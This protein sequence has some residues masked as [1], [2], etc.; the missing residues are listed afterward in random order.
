MF[1]SWMRGLV[2]R[3]ARPT[4][5]GSARPARRRTY[6]PLLEQLEHRL[7]PAQCFWTGAGATGSWKL[8]ANWNI[9][10]PAMGQVIPLA[11]DDIIFPANVASHSS[12]FDIGSV[13]GFFV[14]SIQFQDGGYVLGGAIP[15]GVA[16]AGI[17]CS[18]G[19]TTI[20]APL[21]LVGFVAGGGGGNVANPTSILVANGTQLF[22]DG[23]IQS[24]LYNVP[25]NAPPPS[26]AAG[27]I[28][29]G[30]N[31][32]QIVV[33]ANNTYVG[34]T[35]IAGGF[36]TIETGG[37]LGA[38]NANGVTVSSGAALQ[39]E[40][41][42]G[43]NVSIAGKP[44]TINGTGPTGGGALE[45]F[46]GTWTYSG[47]LQLSGNAAIGADPQ[48]PGSPVPQITINGL[49]TDSNNAPVNPA[50]Q[51]FSMTIAGGE[52]GV[53]SHTGGNVVFTGNQNNVFTG[54]VNVNDGTL[55]LA[56]TPGFVA[57]GQPLVTNPVTPQAVQFLTIGDASGAANTAAVVFSGASNQLPGTAAAAFIGTQVTI[58]SD[59][60]LNMG[61]FSQQIYG[62]NINGGNVL[63][64]NGTLTLTQ[65]TT[66]ANGSGD[67]LS[68]GGGSITT[69]S[70]GL[71]TGTLQIQGSVAKNPR[72]FTV[73][74]GNL[75]IS[76]VVSSSNSQQPV[77]KA[78]P[79]TLTLT[80]SN[81]IT[82]TFT[83]NPGGGTVNL[84]NSTALGTASAVTVNSGTAIQLQGTVTN[85]LNISRPLTINGA[86][87]TS[88][89]ALEN[90]SG[91][92]QWTSTIALAGP[93]FFGLDAGQLTVTGVISGANSLTTNGPGTLMLNAANTYTGATTINGGVLG[94]TGTLY[95]GVTP[96][97]PVTIANGGTLFP[98]AAV[99][100]T[101]AL[102]TNN[103]VLTSPGTGYSLGQFLTITGAGGNPGTG[104][105]AIV[106]G[107]NASGGITALAINSTGG[108]YLPGSVTITSSSGSGATAIVAGVPALFTINDT[109]SFSFGSFFQIN[110]L[111]GA[112]AGG[113]AGFDQLR[114]NAANFAVNLGVGN[115]TFIIPAVRYQAA[116]NQTYAI[117]NTAVAS[118]TVTGTFANFTANPSLFTIP[119][120]FTPLPTT[121]NMRLTYPAA[122]GTSLLLAY[123]G[124]PPVLTALS[125][126]P[127]PVNLGTSTTLNGTFL[128]PDNTPRTIVISWGDGSPNTT[129]NLAASAA[130]TFTFGASSVPPATHTYATTGAFPVNVTITDTTTNLSTFGS[131]TISVFNVRYVAVSSDNT[132]EVRVFNVPANA[133]A[134]DFFA[135]NPFAFPGGVRVAVGDVNGDSIPD[136]ITVPGPGGPPEVK[137][138]DGATGAVIRDFYAYAGSMTAGMFV[139]S[140][141]GN[142]IV[143]GP[144]AGFAPEVKVF[145]A[146]TTTTLF[147]FFAYPGF[148][149]GGVRVA[150]GDVN[151]DATADILTVTGP[152]QAPEVRAFNGLNTAQ[153]Y[154]FF[155]FGGANIP[156][157]AYIASADINGDG[158]ADFIVGA[159]S[160]S[161]P[162]VNVFSGGPT[163]TALRT[164]YA[165]TGS[166]DGGV[167]VGA[168]H[169]FTGNN[170]PEML[171]APGL[172]PSIGGA[173]HGSASQ[174]P[175][176]GIQQVLALDPAMVSIVDA[177]F[178]YGPSFPGGVYVAGNP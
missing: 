63:L 107:V 17:G 5:D 159:G 66:L 123:L 82:S 51:G 111:F 142:R 104:A 50:S 136:I 60:L 146:N 37:A 154:D 23:V 12:F 166:Y 18:A 87:P 156:G 138:F 109:V 77:Q 22:L 30:T 83:L 53:V 59:G 178:A 155:P 147:D 163:F 108:N 133:L 26:A 96:L 54:G 125:A 2:K 24:S 149:T 58:N 98:G 165:Y 62:L 32:G 143:V 47:T 119:N 45:A 43:A 127:N 110:P 57:F 158:F 134:F 76:A 177:F 14:N 94:G 139:G 171:T 81:N 65:A 152:G 167:R 31:N 38:Q 174:I 128:D 97:G 137:V 28:Y 86:G 89:G 126:N 153:L 169:D 102:A 121:A 70:P 61:D 41:P 168:V 161:T 144:D 69:T 173:Q 113:A 80:N 175:Q 78:G 35:V 106:T 20:T 157:G 27:I 15:L 160:G 130:T 172:S 141:G 115:T 176:G 85:P 72:I 100:L 3:Q 36:V 105:T 75:L 162:L 122:A 164:F 101:G 34:S 55:V 44:L 73:N 92:N 150:M 64:N 29:N 11:G 170:L 88:A 84:Q 48:I 39:L 117:I 132:T 145:N 114:I 10:G 90:V 74:S 118:D 79:G 19:V 9:T 120:L 33:A 71:T 25:P 42:A 16:S 135:Y 93:T 40:A 151:G 46:S 103:I 99:S 56:K 67:V 7:V 95:N 21:D 6:R 4:R 13:P 129:I 124:T 1:L 140:N 116:V 68:N 8:A 91:F 49:I 131:L 112:G 52:N 148:V